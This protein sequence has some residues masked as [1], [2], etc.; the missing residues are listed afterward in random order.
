MQA[1]DPLLQ[2]PRS[3]SISRVTCAVLLGGFINIRT[4]G[5]SYSF[6]ML[7]FALT[8]GILF[9]FVAFFSVHSYLIYNRALRTDCVTDNFRRSTGVLMCLVGSF[10]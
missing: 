1:V 7:L 9:S 8:Q 4:L 5:S 6:E 3:S 2:F 10:A